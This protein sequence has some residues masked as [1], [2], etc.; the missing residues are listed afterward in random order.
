MIGC[1]G[2]WRSKIHQL[3]LA[4]VVNR[5][6]FVSIREAHTSKIGGGLPQLWCVPIVATLQGVVEAPIAAGNL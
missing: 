5:F 3:R 1:R 4:S 6:R 2:A